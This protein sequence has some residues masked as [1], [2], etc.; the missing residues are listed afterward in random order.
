M[1]GIYYSKDYS[2][3]YALS[4]Q[5]EQRVHHALGG[6]V[7]FS[8]HFVLE[9]H[10]VLRKERIGFFFVLYKGEIELVSEGNGLF[11]DFLPAD[12]E[13]F[14]TM[15]CG[16]RERFFHGVRNEHLLVYPVGISGYDNVRAV[17]EWSPDGL[18]CLAPHDDRV[19][20]GERL[21]AFQVI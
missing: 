21:E 15:F 10:F 5:V 16:K 13:C 3:Y 6:C 14:A 7:C 12:N 9:K 1:H 2:T 11:V 8:E 19:A 18:K 17:R 20:G 4:L